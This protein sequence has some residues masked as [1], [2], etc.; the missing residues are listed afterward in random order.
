MTEQSKDIENL[1]FLFLKDEISVEQRVTLDAW[2]AQSDKNKMLFDALTNRQILFQKLFDY[3]MLDNAHKS[4]N[5][6]SQLLHKILH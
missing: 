3:Y 5:K 2:I 1:I 4:Q 6:S